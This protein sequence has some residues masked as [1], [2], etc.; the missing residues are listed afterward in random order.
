MSSTL[1]SQRNNT[2]EAEMRTDSGKGKDGVF[3]LH[4]LEAPREFKE[5]LLRHYIKYE[6]RDKDWYYLASYG[7][8]DVYRLAVKALSKDA[9]IGLKKE[10][11]EADKIAPLS[12]FPFLKRSK[13]FLEWRKTTQF[14]K[15]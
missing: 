7:D 4:T 6:G 8:D 12:Q 9:L 11:T 15:E 14:E 3:K 1:R 5:K 13:E 10:K 2:D